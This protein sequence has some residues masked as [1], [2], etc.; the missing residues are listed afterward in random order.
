LGLQNKLKHKKSGDREES[1]GKKKKKTKRRWVL[2][3]LL[4]FHQNIQTQHPTKKKLQ[5]EL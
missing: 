4:L 5:K 1:T 3:F 2:F